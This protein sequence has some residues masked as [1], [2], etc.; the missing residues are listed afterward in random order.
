M[1]HNDFHHGRQHSNRQLTGTTTFSHDKDRGNHGL[2]GTMGWVQNRR[3]FA[4]NV[5]VLQIV[6]KMAPIGAEE[7]EEQSLAAAAS[8]LET[9]LHPQALATAEMYGNMLTVGSRVWISG[10]LVMNDPSG[11]GGQSL[12]AQEVCLLKASWR[13]ITIRYILDQVVEQHLAPEEASEA[14]L[15]HKTKWIM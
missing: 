13:P 14:L 12:W 3:R 2:G 11:A 9:I 7:E 4:D 1:H 8:R 6:E 5:T 10:A 15:C